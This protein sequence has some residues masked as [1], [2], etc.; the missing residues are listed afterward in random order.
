MSWIFSRFDSDSRDST[1]STVSASAVRPM[2]SRCCASFTSFSF[3]L[4]LPFRI[5]PTMKDFTVLIP[6]FNAKEATELTIRTLYAVAKTHIAEF[7]VAD[8][9]NDTVTSSMLDSLAKEYPI[10]ICR[11]DHAL[12]HP[13]AMDFLFKQNIKTPFVFTSDSDV[14]YYSCRDFHDAL[15]HFKNPT[16]ALTGPYVETRK[17]PSTPGSHLSEYIYCWAMAARTGIIKKYG[18]LFLDGLA[19]TENGKHVQ[20]DCG[21]KFF[22]TVCRK[23]GWNFAD[24]SDYKEPLAHRH[25]SAQSRWKEMTQ[26]H[27]HLP[28]DDFKKSMQAVEDEIQDKLNRRIWLDLKAC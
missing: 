24:I 14:E 25:Y 13:T 4:I 23:D 11:P 27:T 5:I 20:Y 22:V 7:I 1:E 18:H 28:I 26:G 19:T 9:S 12:N 8:S 16:V 17:H 2:L 6:V 21:A 3:N 10:N 15:S